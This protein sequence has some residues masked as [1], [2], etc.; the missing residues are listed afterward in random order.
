MKYRNKLQIIAEILETI[1]DGARKTHIMYRANLS[2]KLLCKYLGDVLECE[3]ARIE[4][5]DRYVVAPRGKRFLKKYRAYQDLRE[6][7][8]EELREVAKE[9]AML[10]QMYTNSRL[11]NHGQRIMPIE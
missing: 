1:K 6:R 4:D 8:N 10:E 9:R 2:Y 5:G 11:Q 7:V 3:F